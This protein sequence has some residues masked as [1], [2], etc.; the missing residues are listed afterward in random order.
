MAIADGSD[1]SNSAAGSSITS[2]SDETAEQIA[3][4]PHPRGLGDRQAESFVD[5]GHHAQGG[6]LEE[7]HHPV[8]VDPADELTCPSTST[9]FGPRQPLVAEARGDVGNYG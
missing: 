6:G 2:G 3:G 7:T 1:G 8:V 4:H 5:R 9:S